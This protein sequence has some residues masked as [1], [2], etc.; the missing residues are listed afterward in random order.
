VETYRAL[1]DRSLDL[2]QLTALLMR[3]SK[4]IEVLNEP[5]LGVVCFRYLP[6]GLTSHEAEDEA[7][8]DRL[9]AELVERVVASG[10]ATL[11]STRL[12]GRFAIRFCVLNHRT[13][14][15][16]IERTIALIERLGN[17]LAQR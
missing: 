5:Q 11:S 15:S 8:L 2:A 10:E 13:Q 7:R 17:E 16:D 4:V 1:I 12:S 9:N 3:R 14:T 6:A